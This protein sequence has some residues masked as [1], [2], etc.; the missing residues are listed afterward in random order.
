MT[1]SDSIIDFEQAWANLNDLAHKLREMTK[2]PSIAIAVVENGKARE[3]IAF[4][5]RGDGGTV[6]NHTVYPLASVSKP[7]TTTIAA[8]LLSK[9]NG[10][11]A[12]PLQPWLQRIADLDPAFQLSDPAVTQKLTIADL[13]S[14]RSGL[15][16]HAGDSL[17]DIGWS[18]RE[19]LRRLRFLQLAPY[20]EEYAY[21][22]FGFTEAALALVKGMNATWEDLA[23]ETLFKPL[24]MDATSTSFQVL[25][26]RK[27]RALGYSYHPH[28]GQWFV[29]DPQRFPDFQ[30][31]AGGVSSSIR[32]MQQWLRLQL[33]ITDNPETF[34]AAFFQQLEQTH[35]RYPRNAMPMATYG[36]GWNVP[37]EGDIRSH[38]GGFAMGAATCV[39]INPVTKTGIVVLTNGEP[40]A[41]PEVLGRGWFDL[42]ANATT[43]DKL[44]SDFQKFADKMTAMMHPKPNYDYSKEPNPIVPPLP[45]ERYIGTYSDDFYGKL[46][47]SGTSSLTMTFES[48][49]RPYPLTHRSGNQFLY[50]PIGENAQGLAAVEFLEED[51]NYVRVENLMVAS[52]VGRKIELGNGPAISEFEPGWFVDVFNPI[53]YDGYIEEWQFYGRDD[54]RGE[55]VQ[56]FV[57][58]PEGNEFV[59]HFDSS[60]T[61]IIVPGPQSCITKP[62]QVH[63]GACLG[64]RIFDGERCTMAYSL[65]NSAQTWRMMDMPGTTRIDLNRIYAVSA[66]VL[67]KGKF[68]R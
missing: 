46:Q 63:K 9:S 61:T 39:M 43:V 19:I 65:S 55:R 24:H 31:P 38:S 3:P 68:R 29:R 11:L 10:K 62:I 12:D 57:A 50:Q 18:Q 66:V 37:A 33:G 20:Q 7:I 25:E 67:Q 17:E 53:Q 44:L 1:Q 27:N 47:I 41:I 2:V 40:I 16:D 51:F 28:N 48:S 49:P 60:K 22:N 35:M 23:Q 59:A 54:A 8:R 42:L 30:S 32:D 6:N 5:D 34:D 14:H 64:F 15:P 36:F 45:I 13:F 4:G 26:S 52:P 21:T 56:F 58:F